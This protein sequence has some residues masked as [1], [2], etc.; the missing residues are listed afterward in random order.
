MA[1]LGSSENTKKKGRPV[2]QL[3]SQ[4][5]SIDSFTLY[6]NNQS[7]AFRVDPYNILAIPMQDHLKIIYRKQKQIPYIIQVERLT[8]NYGGF[9]T[10]FKCPL[11]QKR[12]RILYLTAN[13]VLLCRKCLNL[14]YITQRWVPSIRNMIKHSELERSIKALGGDLQYNQRPRYMKRAKFE[15]IRNKANLYEFKWHQALNEEL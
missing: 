10:Y 12:M 7:R 8:C 1:H 9:R 14:G 15:Q 4:T 2:K 5:A 13:C 3:C 11:C 6:K